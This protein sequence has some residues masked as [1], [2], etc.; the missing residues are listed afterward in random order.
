MKS[1]GRFDPGFV[2]HSFSG[3]VEA[4]QELAT[5]NGYVS[6]SGSLT[7]SGNRRAAKVACAVPADRM[8]VETDAPDLMPVTGEDGQPSGSWGRP[9]GV[10]V[11]ANL[12]HVARRLAALR[13][14]TEREVSEITESNARRLFSTCMQGDAG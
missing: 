2:V 7:L 12:V 6:F 11:P 13:G 4:M 10:N 1:I 5:L 3:S 14:M 9:S 8:L